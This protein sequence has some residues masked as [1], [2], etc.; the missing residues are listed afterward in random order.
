MLPRTLSVADG[1]P[2]VAGDVTHFVML[3]YKLGSHVTSSPFYVT[4]L[5]GLSI[6]IGLPWLRFH[7][8]IVDLE[9]DQI[10]FNSSFCY[11]NCMPSKIIIL[12]RVIRKAATVNKLDIN[13]ISA[14]AYNLLARQKGSEI[15]ALTI[16]AFDDAIAKYD[17]YMELML[18][19]DSPELKAAVRAKLNGG[20]DN[21]LTD[22]RQFGD[23]F[24]R[25]KP[26]SFPLT[27]RTT[28]RF[29]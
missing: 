13:L 28:T 23:L 1:S 6:I 5:G 16:S 14:L 24:P 10:I 18:Q 17:R 15:F 29:P 20:V 4:K 19:G 25:S 21:D 26:K 3:D 11:Q 27:A 8:A 9:Q 7:R 2:S 22:L 12:C